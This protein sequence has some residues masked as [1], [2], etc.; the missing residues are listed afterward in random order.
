MWLR[1][2]KANEG[3]TFIMDKGEMSGG[4]EEARTCPDGLD[5]GEKPLR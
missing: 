5:G 1:L 4:T 3:G 2:K